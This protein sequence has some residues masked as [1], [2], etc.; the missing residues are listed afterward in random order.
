MNKSKRVFLKTGTALLATMGMAPL[1][2]FAGREGGVDIVLSATDGEQKAGGTLSLSKS[3]LAKLQEMKPKERP[4]YIG[5]LIYRW[6][7]KR[8]PKMAWAKVGGKISNDITRQIMKQLD[9]K[10]LGEG[11]KPLPKLRIRIKVKFS[12]PDNWEISV[13]IKF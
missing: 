9:G 6:L 12:P 10:G 2:A 7:K 11:D 1:A 4:V 13:E 3:Q 5:E 8:F